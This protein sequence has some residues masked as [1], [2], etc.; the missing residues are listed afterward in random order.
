MKQ[1]LSNNHPMVA[2]FRALS[3]TKSSVLLPFINYLLKNVVFYAVNRVFHCVK[4]AI[5]TH[6]QGF[7]NTLI[8]GYR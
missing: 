7:C 1:K 6:F 5:W 4:E 3:K 8:G 2:I